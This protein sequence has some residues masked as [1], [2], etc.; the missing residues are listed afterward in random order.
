MKTIQVL[1]GRRPLHILSAGGKSIFK[2][3]K[4]NRLVNASI[5]YQY[6]VIDAA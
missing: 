3:G 6:F 4:I 2:P 5:F 1:P